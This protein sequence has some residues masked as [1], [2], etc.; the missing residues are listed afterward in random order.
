MK[1]LAVLLAVLAISFSANAQIW[2]TAEYSHFFAKENAGGVIDRYGSNGFAIGAEY[3]EFFNDW[4]S[5][6]LGLK[7]RGDFS[8]DKTTDIQHNFFALDLPI[9]ARGTMPFRYDLKGFVDAGPVVSFGLSFKELMKNGWS[10]NLFKDDVKRVLL[11][12]HVGVGV[13]YMDTYR[14]SINFEPC[15]I[16]QSKITGVKVKDSSLSLSFAYRF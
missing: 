4:F 13:T 15:F 8:K 3:E 12:A 11:Y 6:G 14:F 16:N 7:F 2:A 10:Y 9:L 1:K 5:L